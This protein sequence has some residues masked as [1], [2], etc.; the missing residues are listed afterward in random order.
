MLLI[1][2]CETRESPT[3]SINQTVAVTLLYKR[4]L[5][6]NSGLE[7]LCL[8]KMELLLQSLFLILVVLLVA[9]GAKN[10]YFRKTY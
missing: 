5:S 3:E 7:L 6:V 2:M 8:R 4:I 9:I 10:P 1:V